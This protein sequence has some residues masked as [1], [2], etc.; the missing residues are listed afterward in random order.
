M[1]PFKFLAF[2]VLFWSINGAYAQ[3]SSWDIEIRGTPT[4]PV[5]G[6]YIYCPDDAYS[7][8]FKC[9]IFGSI[10]GK[11]KW[12]VK[13]G[14]IVWLNDLVTSVETENLQSIMVVWDTVKA[15]SS[16]GGIYWDAPKG[17][18]TL[19]ISEGN[20]KEKLDQL[21]RTKT[22]SIHTLKG[23]P[24]P[25]ISDLTLPLCT[26]NHNIAPGFTMEYPDTKK[27]VEMFEW[28]L[29][30]GMSVNLNCDGSDDEIQSATTVHD[31][32]F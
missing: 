13:N 11:F 8:S 4:S 22:I 3:K 21:S 19:T 26:A 17:E 29:P 14:K 20:A 18:I 24:E 15:T 12:E 28:T 27:S 9:D 7:T 31:D 25:K 32:F 6:S 16:N 2:C 23:M 30:P 10:N 1:K 5:A